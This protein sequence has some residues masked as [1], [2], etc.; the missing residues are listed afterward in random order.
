L[1]LH[2]QG[3]RETFYLSPLIPLSMKWRGGKQEDPRGAIAEGFKR[4]FF[5]KNIDFYKGG[6]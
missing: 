3:A 1:G 4:R 6:G 5:G 2:P